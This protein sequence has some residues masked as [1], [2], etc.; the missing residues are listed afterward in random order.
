MI[1]PESAEIFCINQKTKG[2]FQFEILNV[3]VSQLFPFHFKT[4]NY[5]IGLW[6]LCMF[7]AFISART[8][9]RRQNLASLDVRCRRLTTVPALKGSKSHNKSGHHKYVYSYSAGI[10][11]RVVISA[12]ARRWTNVG[13][14]LG[15]RRTS[16][17]RQIHIK[18]SIIP[19]YLT[20][21]VFLQLCVIYNC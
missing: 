11:F 7:F 8:S 18:I 17:N 3:L 9:F 4:Y 14:M 5:V 16:S 21:N 20:S 19:W 1:S 10:D 13:L 12:N 15:Q 2:L 6:S